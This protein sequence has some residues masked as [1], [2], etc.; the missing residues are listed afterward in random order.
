MKEVS[1]CI[2]YTVNHRLCGS[3][4][5]ELWLAY[6][7]LPTKGAHQK[8]ERTIARDRNVSGSGM[9]QMVFGS[10]LDCESVAREMVV[11]ERNKQQ[12]ISARKIPSGTVVYSGQ[13]TEIF[14][15]K[16]LKRFK[17]NTCKVS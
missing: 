17:R 8:H 15:G 16:R 1:Y 2:V 10:R 7:P 9:E 12:S 3:I 5:E 6:C 11:C 13:D 4:S 14:I